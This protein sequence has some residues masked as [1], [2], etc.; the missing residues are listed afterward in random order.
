MFSRTCIS[1]WRRLSTFPIKWNGLRDYEIVSITD[2]LPSVNEFLRTTFLQ[3]DPLIRAM[4]I[5]PP[6]LEYEELILGDLGK[7]HLLAARRRGSADFL[8]VCQSVHKTNDRA[9]FQEVKINDKRVVEL[10]YLFMYLELSFDL[11]K[12]YQVTDIWHIKCIGVSK[13]AKGMALE[14]ELI[15]ASLA[16]AHCRGVPVAWII[17]HTPRLEKTARRMAFKK[18]LSLK[19]DNII[20]SKGEHL[21]RDKNLNKLEGH[22]AIYARNVY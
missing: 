5:V 16:E 4:G 7:T 11:F 14:R 10:C 13:T 20:N 6:N 22:I 21:F 19:Y 12:Y 2:K 1:L 8:A 17:A 3:D 9:P 18:H 15:R